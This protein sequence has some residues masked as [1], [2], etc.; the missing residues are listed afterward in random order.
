VMEDEKFIAGDLDTGF[1]DG[2][3]KRQ[4]V[5]KPDEVTKDLAVIAASL[6]ALRQKSD[7]KKHH[8]V[9]TGRWAAAG[10]S[11]SLSRRK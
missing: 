6:V 7:S 4:A 5:N 3:M 8:T 10:R 11:E 9:N 1:I 2:F